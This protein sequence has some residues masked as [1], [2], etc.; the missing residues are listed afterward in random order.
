MGV[1]AVL[2]MPIR[3]SEGSAN[4]FSIC[5]QHTIE[6]R[7]VLQGKSKQDSVK[8]AATIWK[9]IGGSAWWLQ[10]LHCS[11]LCES[12][13][14]WKKPCLTFCHIECSTGCRPGDVENH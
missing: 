7:V 9:P 10:D 1:H 4:P 8:V 14:L 12:N 2:E 3:K 13:S 11:F 6:V 5:E